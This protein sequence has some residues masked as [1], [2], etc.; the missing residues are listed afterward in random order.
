MH[1]AIVQVILKSTTHCTVRLVVV[2]PVILSNQQSN[3]L[4]STCTRILLEDLVF[5][6]NSRG[7]PSKKSFN[8][9]KTSEI[10][11]GVVKTVFDEKLHISGK[12]N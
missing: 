10:I 11:F 2:C 9:G 3:A 6:W 4:L 7:K 1:I 8:G 5:V 12:L